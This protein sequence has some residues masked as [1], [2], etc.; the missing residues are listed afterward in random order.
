MYCMGIQEHG[1]CSRGWGVGGVRLGAM[2]KGC[3]C[4]SGFKRLGSDG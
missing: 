2:V 3:P 1:G 4:R